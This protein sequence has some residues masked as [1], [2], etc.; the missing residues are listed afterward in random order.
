MTDIVD[1]VELNSIQWG[2]CIDECSEYWCF[3]S[4]SVIEIMRVTVW[5]MT[6]IMIWRNN[7]WIWASCLIEG[8][9][10]AQRREFN[11]EEID[12]LV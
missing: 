3:R 6:E 9:L 11:D 8:F 12:G 10:M 1:D 5:M 7:A 4:S 2:V